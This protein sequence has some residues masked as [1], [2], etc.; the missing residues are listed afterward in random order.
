M[1]YKNNISQ[2]PHTYTVK[3]I[4]VWRQYAYAIFWIA[5][6]AFFALILTPSL[7]EAGHVWATTL[8]GGR[9]TGETLDI[10]SNSD[11]TWSGGNQLIITTGG[12]VFTTFCAMLFLI[13]DDSR[14]NFI[15]TVMA[16]DSFVYSISGLGDSSQ[17]LQMH[18]VGPLIGIALFSL[19]V[20]LIAGYLAITRINALNHKVNYNAMYEL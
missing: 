13:F 20:A 12:M 9:V 10:F 15:A 14:S 19:I 16:G 5:V 4:N 18:A 2:Y 6:C 3:S 11:T 1:R 17:L 8:T 7:H